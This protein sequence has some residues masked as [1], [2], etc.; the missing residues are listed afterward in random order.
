MILLIDNY[1]SF[2]YNIF[3]YLAS[4]GVEVTIYRNDQLTIET[5]SKLDPEAIVLSPG[6]GTPDEAGLSKEIVKAFYRKIPILGVCLGHQ[7]IANALDASIIQASTIKHGKTSLI[8]HDG[9]G[10]FSYLPQPLEVMRY[11][12][13]VIDQQTLPDELEVVSSS[14]EDNEIMAIKHRKYPVYGIQFHP[15]SIGTLTGKKMIRNFLEEIRE[16]L[17]HEKLS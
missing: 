3:H 6:P 1:D 14:L 16:E 8:T 2:T 4:E 10:L 11:H 17:R 13:L 12:S 7:V 9:H 15:E 5:I